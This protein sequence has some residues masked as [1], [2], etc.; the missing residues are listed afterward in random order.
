MAT[1]KKVKIKKLVSKNLREILRYFKYAEVGCMDEKGGHILHVFHKKIDKH[2]LEFVVDFLA[3]KP[4]DIFRYVYG[5]NEIIY[6]E[7]A[8]CERWPC[9]PNN[10]HFKPILAL[11]AV[12]D[13][14]QFNKGKGGKSYNA[15][16]KW[17]KDH[18]LEYSDQEIRS[19]IRTMIDYDLI[20]VSKFTNIFW[21]KP[22]LKEL[23]EEINVT[24]TCLTK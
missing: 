14:T 2:G 16:K 3:E 18:S 11:R 9:S 13:L 6:N 5:M 19:H 17:Y 1:A 23:A 7:E 12:T 22:W 20:K 21:Y 8:F 15:I 10:V 4:D 24:L